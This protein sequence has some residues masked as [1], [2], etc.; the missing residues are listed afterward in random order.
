MANSHEKLSKSL[1]IDDSGLDELDE[2]QQQLD[3]SLSPEE[4]EAREMDV[5]RQK[6][7][8][9][10]AELNSEIEDITNSNDDEEFIKKSLKMV[11]KKGFKILNTVQKEIENDPRERAIE[12]A[13]QT[14][15]AITK[16]V[17]TLD[18]Y[19]KGETQLKQSKEKIELRRAELEN[20]LGGS[21]SI[22][23]S[24]TVVVATTNDI[25][26]Q[27]LEQ[28]KNKNDDKVI[29]ADITVEDITTNDVEVDK[30]ESI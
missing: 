28:E 11:T 6:Q 18:K 14:M 25:I 13:S 17:E 30:D 3:G 10:L 26:K 20:N 23:S 1:G 7:K 5:L 22:G 19:N 24:N 27:M 16:A 8:E 21:N 12:V 9:E 4:I 29:E 15:G 2:L